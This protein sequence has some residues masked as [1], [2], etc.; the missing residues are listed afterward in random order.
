MPPLP[1]SPPP[2][3]LESLASYERVALLGAALSSTF[4]LDA[5]PASNAFD[6][7]LGSLV[8]TGWEVGAWVSVL[9]PTHTS[10][11]AVVVYNRQDSPAYQAWLSPFE[12]RN[13]RSQARDPHQCP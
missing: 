11:V 10:V 8:A 6:G 12:V 3:P 4:S 2:L 5:F 7:D 1:P 9:V 13:M